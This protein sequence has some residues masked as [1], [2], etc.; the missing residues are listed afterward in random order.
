MHTQRVQNRCTGCPTSISP[1]SNPHILKSIWPMT[2]IL[3]VMSCLWA[4]IWLFTIKNVWKFQK[5]KKISEMAPLATWSSSELVKKSL[6]EKINDM[7]KMLNRWFIALNFWYKNG[8]IWSVAFF[9]FHV[10]TNWFNLIFL[11]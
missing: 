8:K 11:A 3:V 9:N 1:I 6:R 4:Y 10:S 2:K 7:T 5:L